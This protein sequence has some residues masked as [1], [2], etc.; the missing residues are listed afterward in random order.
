[1][2]GQDQKALASYEQ[3]LKHVPNSQKDEQLW[4]GVGILYQKV[5][6]LS[7]L[8]I[9]FK[10]KLEDWNN[11]E[12]S[13]RNALRLD[14]NP[15]LKGEI[16]YN[17]GMVLKSKGDYPEAVKVH[18]LFKNSIHF[19]QYLTKCILSESFPPEKIVEILCQSGQ[20]QEKMNDVTFSL[21]SILQHL[22]G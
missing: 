4:Y 10:I 18:P 15:V 3:A 21:L 20:L 13:F 11:A 5:Q 8:V 2:I 14:P 7:G 9:N 19:Q 16:L 6:F 1:M 17:L 22:L 12:M